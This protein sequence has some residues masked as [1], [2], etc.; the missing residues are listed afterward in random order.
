MWVNCS[1]WAGQ[2]GLIDCQIFQYTWPTSDVSGKMMEFSS[3]V[4]WQVESCEKLA[5]KAQVFHKKTNNLQ[6][7]CLKDSWFNLCPRNYPLSFFRF[8]MNGK[9]L[10]KDRNWGFISCTFSLQPLSFW[11][12]LSDLHRLHSIFYF[13]VPHHTIASFSVISCHHTFIPFSGHHS[14]ISTDFSLLPSIPLFLCHT[15]TIDIFF[16]GASFK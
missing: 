5:R 11:S 13:S 4:D 1:K 8:L 3:L 16:G 2:C 10:R 9:Y 7:I 12:D 14:F 6:S 15:N